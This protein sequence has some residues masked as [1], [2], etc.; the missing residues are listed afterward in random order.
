MQALPSLLLMIG[1]RWGRSLVGASILSA[2]IWSFLP[3]IPAFARPWP[4]ALAIVAVFALFGAV[5]ALVGWRARRRARAVEQA[6]AGDGAGDA[7]GAPGTDQAGAA[8]ELAA[9]RT[10][11]REALA[12]LRRRGVRRVYE[13]P[14][15]VVIGPPGAGKTTALRQSGLHFPLDAEQAEPLQGVGGTRLCDWWFC[16]EAVLIDTAGRYTTQDSNRHIDKAGW[17]GFLDMLRRV[18]P[19]QPVNGVLVVIALSEL[20]ES[21]EEQRA[22]HAR[23]I[24]LRINELT[25]RLRL[26]LPVYLVISKMDRL[27]GFDMFFEDLDAQARA[28]VWGVTFGLDEE[29]AAFGPAFRELLARIDARLIDRL[30]AERSTDRR[31][32]LSGF[33]LQLASIE[34]VLTSFLATAFAGSRIDPAPF[35]R[36][37]YL[38]SAT[39]SG[40]PFDRLTGMLARSFAIDQRQAPPHRPAAARGYFLTRMMR[41]VILGETPLVAIRPGRYRRRKL[42]RAAALVA[43][44][45]LTLVGLGTIWG[46]DVEARVAIDRKGDAFESYRRDVGRFPSAVIG[47]HDDLEQVATLLD[48]A[49]GLAAG[50][51][52][53]LAG[54]AGLSTRPNL[55][56]AGVAAYDDALDHLLYPR[57]VWRL[58]RQMRAGMQDPDTLYGATRV[59]LLL[60]GNGPHEPDLIRQWI[61][62]DWSRRFPGVLNAT[63][64]ADLARHLDALLAQPLPAGQLPL[65]GALVAASRAAF[66][67]VTPAQRIYDRLRAEARAGGD[68]VGWSPVTALGDAAAST[69]ARGSG[70]SLVAGI[71]AFLT[72]P[73][74]AAIMQ[75]DLPP[76][77]RLVADE[78][79]VVG[80]DPGI[81]TGGAD[82]ATLEQQVAQLWADDAIAQWSALLGDLDLLPFG[83]RE[84]AENQLYLLSSPQS[85]LRDML[86]SIAHALAIGKLPANSPSEAVAAS[87]DR[88]LGE[89]VRA[90]GPPKASR[91]AHRLV[92]R[93]RSTASSAWWQRST[94][95]SPPATA[96]RPPCPRSPSNPPIRRSCCGRKPRAS[97]RRC[98][99]GSGRWRMRAQARW[100]RRRARPPRAPTTRRPGPMPPAARWSPATT[101]STP[102]APTT[103]RWPISPA[104][105]PRAARWTRISRRAWHP[106]STPRARP[107]ACIRPAACSRRSRWRSWRRSS[108]RPRSGGRFSRRAACRCCISRSASRHRPASPSGWAATR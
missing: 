10:R 44:A 47:D 94:T 29:Q 95:S 65:D 75:R 32:I 41:E 24:R 90:G 31:A 9:L 89:A 18:R 84:R 74:F 79:W 4:R 3:A 1:S 81:A 13:L 63:L 43:V 12:N 83:T 82:V 59:Y 92:G 80:Q 103:R 19:R 91:A 2:L 52:Q 14:W 17:L 48:E 100:G 56:A 68:A 62:A 78:S 96:R 26:R 30:Q 104:C 71:P 64:R 7:K 101:R 97:R 34:T 51:P 61:E 69:F 40:T 22:A 98:R 36:G 45:V 93:R 87:W 108:A 76:A 25:E 77:A 15:Y 57:L 42:L 6:I 86:V 58:E 105:W 49:A 70:T 8:A 106:M 73:A 50:S 67:H 27:A 53:P 54:L 11:L 38:T 5:T 46:A 99:N 35:L 23:A 20:L 39:Q 37:V 107:G 21:T 55:A 16:E 28:Q 88:Q 72:G 60:G 33:P 66:S 85:P 102:A